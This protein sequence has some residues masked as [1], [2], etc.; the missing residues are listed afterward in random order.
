MGVSSSGAQ[1]DQSATQAAVLQERIDAVQK[2]N[3]ALQQDCVEI[4]RSA[5]LVK[6]LSRC[7]H[8]PDTLSPTQSV[9]LAVIAH[10]FHPTRLTVQLAS[11]YGMHSSVPVTAKGASA[12]IRSLHS[13]AWNSVQQ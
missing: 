11:M 3:N 9:H 4:Q 1:R 7:P 10:N 13:L 2:K 5:V 8:A 6:S 12:G